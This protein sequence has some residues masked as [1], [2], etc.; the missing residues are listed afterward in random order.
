M[1]KSPPKWHRLP[2][3]SHLLLYRFDW[4]SD[5][6]TL[7]LTD[8]QK[9]YVELLS[10]KQ[11]VKRAFHYNTVGNAGIEPQ[12]NLSEFYLLLGRLEAGLTMANTTRVSSSN[13]SGLQLE[14]QV[15]FPSN[16]QY[17]SQS[18]S[19][20]LFNPNPVLSW[21]FMV[22][23]LPSNDPLHVMAFQTLL[24]GLLGV[25]DAQHNQ[26]GDLCTLLKKK[27]FHLRHLKDEIGAKNEPAIHKDAYSPFERA[28]WI[29][30]WLVDRSQGDE[31]D[32][33]NIV[34]RSFSPVADLL[35]GYHARGCIW[36][37]KRARLIKLD[38]AALLEHNNNEEE[39]DDETTESEGESESIPKLIR[40]N[41]VLSSPL[42][43]PRK[44]RLT[45]AAESALKREL[46]SEQPPPLTFK[47]PRLEASSSVETP[48]L[49]ESAAIKTPADYNESD[50]NNNN[51]YG[52]VFGGAEGDSVS[53][54]ASAASSPTPVVPAAKRRPK[55]RF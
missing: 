38:N 2:I 24:A 50:G 31:D 13:S 46:E 35:W 19:Q 33:V 48:P 34:R 3:D 32:I 11:I 25:I 37:D 41:S 8:L 27:D 52:N 55:R 12:A 45:S 7:Y 47:K 53:S 39:N 16:D 40:R 14:L 21:H 26:I 17:A 42:Q 28:P 54:A 10:Y 23:P 18:Q 20:R 36:T 49:S 44:P 30:Q 51:N 1:E 4:G 5:Y 6:Y 29:T 9:V 43:S 15:T 22:R